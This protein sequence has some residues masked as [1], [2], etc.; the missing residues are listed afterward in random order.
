LAARPERT[1]GNFFHD[2]VAAHGLDELFFG[3]LVVLL[4]LIL[5]IVA[6]YRGAVLVVWDDGDLA[7]LV[8]TERFAL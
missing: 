1:L 4:I 7:A 8:L 2:V 3:F 5:E 6:M